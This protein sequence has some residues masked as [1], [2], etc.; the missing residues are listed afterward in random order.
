MYMFLKTNWCVSLPQPPPRT[1][2]NLITS[3]H[4]LAYVMSSLYY[5]HSWLLHEL[6][7]MIN[8]NPEPANRVPPPRAGDEPRIISAP[9]ALTTREG[10]VDVLGASILDG[11]LRDKFVHGPGTN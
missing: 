9:R 5:L 6:T 7:F 3:I 11:F 8:A 1:P 4:H 10:K 2:Q